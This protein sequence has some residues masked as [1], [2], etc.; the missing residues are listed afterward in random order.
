LPPAVQRENFQKN[1]RH[2]QAITAFELFE[3]RS[4]YTCGESGWEAVADSALDWAL[5]PTAGDLSRG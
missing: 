4:H 1:A 2:S 5:T 3:G